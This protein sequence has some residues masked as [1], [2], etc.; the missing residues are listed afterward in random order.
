[1]I[2]FNPYDYDFHEDP[3]PIY[4]RL[5]A[6]APVYWNDEIGFWALCC[7]T[8]TR[9]CRVLPCFAPQITS[10]TQGSSSQLR[11]ASGDRVFH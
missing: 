11:D 1:M 9:F 3:Y 5:R 4:A 10:E 8:Q 2:D 6:E 7:S